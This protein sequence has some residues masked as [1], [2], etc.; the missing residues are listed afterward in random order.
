MKLKV[1]EPLRML[2]KD[3]VWV[4]EIDCWFENLGQKKRARHAFITAY[5]VI[6]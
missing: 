4:F 6:R 5:L 2:F 1:V 3:E